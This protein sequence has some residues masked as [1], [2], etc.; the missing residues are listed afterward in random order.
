MA[1][2]ATTA[3]PKATSPTSAV[4]SPAH[5]PQPELVA[6]DFG[7]EDDDDNDDGDSALGSNCDR[8]DSTASASTSIFEYRTIQGRTYHSGRF[9]LEYFTPNDDRHNESDDI[10]HHCLT[11]ALDNKLYLPP[12]KKDIK[13]VLD[14]GTGTGIWA[15]DFA[16]EFPGVEVTG[17]DISPRQPSWVPPNVRFE[18]DDAT[19]P[20]TWDDNHFDFVHLRYLLGS[21]DDWGQLL[22]QAYRVTAPGGWVESGEPEID[23]RSD[24]G[25][26]MP[27]SALATWGRMCSEAGKKTGRSFT[28]ISDGT[29]KK[30]FEEAGF[31]NIQVVDRKVAVGD[32]PRDPKQAEIGRYL[33]ITIDNDLEGYSSFMW[34]QVLNWPA[35]EYQPFLMRTRKEMR[36][37]SIHPYF[38]HR[39]VYGQK[40]E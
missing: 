28:I 11:L 36:N 31:V 1:E 27:G 19:E 4:E 24:D 10:N 14:I 20:W 15:M 30:A 3:S 34:H 22:K 13:R 5:A 2:P 7:V 38:R 18:V 26:V 9:N 39:Y 17:T 23:F 29:Q 25:T 8:F 35:D 16:D 33:W 12:L 40:P 37:K 21:I 32:W 6:A